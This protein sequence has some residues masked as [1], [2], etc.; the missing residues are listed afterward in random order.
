MAIACT[1][2]SG[3]NIEVNIVQQQSTCPSYLMR[4]EFVAQVYMLK[5]YFVNFYVS[6]F[7]ELTSHW[8][9]LC[10]FC[11]SENMPSWMFPAFPTIPV[12]PLCES[13]CINVR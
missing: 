12:L 3:L 7:E 10:N 5:L 11:H 6:A 1:V 2:L 8:Y 4:P 13:L 9:E